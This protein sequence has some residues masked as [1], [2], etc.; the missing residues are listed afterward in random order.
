MSVEINLAE[1]SRVLPRYPHEL[2][3]NDGEV[4]TIEECLDGIMVCGDYD[5]IPN[6]TKPTAEVALA[7]GG[8]IKGLIG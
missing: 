5:I 2:R 1:D 4:S 3:H 7:M 6:G 8:V